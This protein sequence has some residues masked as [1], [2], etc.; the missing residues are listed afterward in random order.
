MEEGDKTTSL[1]RALTILEDARDTVYATGTVPADMIQSLC[2]ELKTLTRSE[3]EPEHLSTA[4]KRQRDDS[5]ED[6]RTTRA[7]KRAISSSSTDSESS[8][9]T[10]T[11]DISASDSPLS[12][13][14][15]YSLPYSDD[16]SFGAFDD[17]FITTDPELVLV[18]AA[19]YIF[20]PFD[21]CFEALDNWM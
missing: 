8:L 5:I 12:S 21:E 9:S 18:K 6:M 13:P 7:M 16:F 1:R 11:Y 10:S 4:G 20:D 14:A 2:T 15:A 17:E 19:N 3:P